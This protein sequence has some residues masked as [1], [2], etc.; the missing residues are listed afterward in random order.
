MAL[1]D[2]D[3]V[4]PAGAL[5]RAALVESIPSEYGGGID[6]LSA[7]DPSWTARALDRVGEQ[8]GLQIEY[9]ARSALTSITQGVANQLLSLN[10][11]ERDARNAMDNLQSLVVIAMLV[12]DVRGRSSIDD[13]AINTAYR[14]AC[15]V[16]PC[17][18]E[19]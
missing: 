1:F 18:P 12:T 8:I 6:A 15:P 9:S 16:Y 19:P 17:T 3:D 4:P 14:L 7:A 2:K 5:V 11:D 10:A 13:S